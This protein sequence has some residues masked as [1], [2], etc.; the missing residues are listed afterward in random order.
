M[1]I[2]YTNVHYG[3]GGGHVTYIV[4]LLNT[5]GH[6]H[7]VWLGTPGVS[8]LY[9]YVKQ[10]PYIRLVDL[11]FTARFFPLLREVR[12]LHKFMEAEKFDVV[13]VNSSADHRHVMLAR[14]GLKS[15]PKIVWT[16]HNDR[17][18]NSIGHRARA[19]WGTDRV[20]AVSDYVGASLFDSPYR[21]IPVDV[22]RHGVDTHYLHPLSAEQRAQLR[23]RLL[24][25]LEEGVL[26]FG[27]VGGTDY[28]KGWLDLVDGVALLTPELRRRVRIVVA[29]D[30]PDAFRLEKLQASGIADQVIFPGLVDDIRDVLGACD[31]G[32]VLSHQE[33]LS[34][35][36]RETMAM[37]LPVLISDAGGLP[38]N[39]G[40]SAEGWVVPVKSPS[41]VADAVK[42]ILSLPR[43]RLTEMGQAARRRSE[44][45]FDLSFFAQRTL[46][47][48]LSALGQSAQ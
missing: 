38:E 39:I 31:V 15:P 12:Q 14:I 21:D 48:Y 41:S 20:I 24:G 32:F 17:R 16:R 34:F 8:R 18:V 7:E 26:V 28:E 27:S 9:R 6:Q 37:G 42:E 40:S 13:H 35:A 25:V 30:P 1:K 47:A 5:L 19:K 46:Q 22:I 4:N 10:M 36:C 43:T 11:C 23:E 44:S 2:L 29:G 33:A 45:D 3:N